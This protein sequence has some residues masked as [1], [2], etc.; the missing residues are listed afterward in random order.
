MILSDQGRDGDSDP[1]KLRAVNLVIVQKG[2]QKCRQRRGF[3]RER[4]DKIKGNRLVGEF[5]QTKIGQDK[6]QAVFTH[7]NSDRKP[8]VRNDVQ[9]LGFAPSGG[10]FFA[11]ILHQP[12][13][14]QLV[15]ILI[16]RGHADAAFRCQHLLGAEFLCVIQGVIDFAPDRNRS[17]SDYRCHLVV[18][19]LLF[20]EHENLLFP[21]LLF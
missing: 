8:G 16:Q 11:G 17:L 18:S 14:H 6:T 4:G 21:F 7:G 3:F 5:M 2:F 20:G 19:S 1:E 15:E 13:F 10:F 12:F 9:S